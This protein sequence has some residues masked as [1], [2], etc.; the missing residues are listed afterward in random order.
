MNNTFKVFWGSY[1]MTPVGF[2][3]HRKWIP[4]YE[5]E[6][7]IEDQRKSN[8]DNFEDFSDYKLIKSAVSFSYE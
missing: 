2:D 6:I 1:S 5:I 8:E 3:F 4:N 7:S